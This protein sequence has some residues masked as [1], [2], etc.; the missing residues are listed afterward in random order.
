MGYCASVIPVPLQASL[1]KPSCGGLSLL[2]TY[3]HHFQYIRMNSQNLHVQ[4]YGRLLYVSMLL[5][6]FENGNDEFAESN[7]ADEINNL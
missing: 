4:N 2:F 5:Q 3:L 1:L 6:L 7:F